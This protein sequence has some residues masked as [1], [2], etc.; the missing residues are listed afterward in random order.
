MKTLA[1]SM[2]L[3]G[4]VLVLG[5]GSPEATRTRGQG[6]GADVG[7]RR[8]TVRLHGGS[9]PFWKTPDRIPEEQHPPLAPARQAQRQD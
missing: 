6:P 7:N 9:D 2:L 8:E 3:I 5:C 4:L 1:L